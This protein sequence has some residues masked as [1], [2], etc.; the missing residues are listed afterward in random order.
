MCGNKNDERVPK[1]KNYAWL[2]PEKIFKSG[3]D[4]F[5]RLI[6]PCDIR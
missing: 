1:W 5:D 2:R 3:Y 4:I 6:E